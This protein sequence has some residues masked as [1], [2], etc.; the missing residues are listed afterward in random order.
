MLITENRND[1]AC[2]LFEF[3][4]TRVNLDLMGW[5]EIDIFSHSITK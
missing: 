2:K 4:P 5:N 1:I 3:L